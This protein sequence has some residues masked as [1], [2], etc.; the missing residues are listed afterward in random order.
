M[1]IPDPSVS[2]PPPGGDQRD[3]FT[4]NAFTLWTNVACLIF[5]ILRLVTRLKIQKTRLWWDDHFII[6]AMVS[7]SH[8]E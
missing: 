5:V 8:C 2:I 3:G 1:T 7:C 4:L 6:V